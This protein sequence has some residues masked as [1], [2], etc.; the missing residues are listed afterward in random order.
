MLVSNWWQVCTW[1]LRWQKCGIMMVHSWVKPDVL[2]KQ[3]VDCSPPY[4][5]FYGKESENLTNLNTAI[6]LL[7]EFQ[8]NISVA[9]F[10]S[11]LSSPLKHWDELLM[12]IDC[13]VRLQAYY[14]GGLT[15]TP[16]LTKV[17]KTENYRVLTKMWTTFQV[18]KDFV[19]TNVFHQQLY[20]L[21]PK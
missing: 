11:V 7:F 17:S 15:L 9:I 1:H 12:S 2:F 19:R 20:I 8:Y 18:Q 10:L 14:E 13:K 5:A 4:T 16:T 21:W 3:N 6:N